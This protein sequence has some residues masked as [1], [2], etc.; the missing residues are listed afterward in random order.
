MIYTS[1]EMIRD[2]QAGKAEGWTFFQENYAPVVTK[3]LA[4]YDPEHAAAML[5]IV[6]ARVRETRLDGLDPAPER[7]FVAWLRQQALAGVDAAAADIPLDLQTLGGA[8]ESLTVVEKEAVWLETM[9]YSSEEAGRMLRMAPGTAEKVRE[10]A[11]ELIR[12]RVDRW[13]RTLL[14]E[15]GFPL[16]REA[17]AGATPECVSVRGLLDMIDGRATWAARSAM[18]RHVNGCWHC[19]DHFCRMHEACDLL[20]KSSR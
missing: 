9:R 13:R 3:I 8:L 14:V 16:G 7:H 2:C 20:R 17:A 11:A 5:E 18:E 19:V 4:H 1:Y 6:L 10:R 15:N 12:G